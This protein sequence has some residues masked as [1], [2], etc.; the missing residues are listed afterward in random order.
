LFVSAERWHWS[1]QVADKSYL[2]VGVEWD[3]F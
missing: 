1:D 2:S 3:R